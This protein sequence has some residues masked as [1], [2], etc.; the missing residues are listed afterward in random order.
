MDPHHGRGYGEWQLTTSTHGDCDSTEQQPTSLSGHPGEHAA[1][2]SMGALI[3]QESSNAIRVSNNLKGVREDLRKEQQKVFERQ[4]RAKLVLIYGR[5]VNSV[6]Q[7]DA[8]TWKFPSPP[9]LDPF[10]IEGGLWLGL[11]DLEGL[12]QG[13]EHQA[14]ESQLVYDNLQRRRSSYAI[15]FLGYI[16]ISE[17]LQ[18]ELELFSRQQQKLQEQIVDLRG[19][20]ESL[21]DWN[22]RMSATAS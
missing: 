17:Q 22:R 12:Q 20:Y 6:L 1:A 11:R 8:Q 3:S 5:S 21:K 18:G 4:E 10:Q 16:S 19:V 14:Q 2:I 7:Q 15:F 13:L 9:F